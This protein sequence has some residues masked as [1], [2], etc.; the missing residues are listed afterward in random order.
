MV[1]SLV[2]SIR[3]TLSMIRFSHSVFALPFAL[4]SLFLAA[5]GWPSGR[6]LLW[7]LAAMVA[8]RS[9]AMGMNRLADRR[10][11]A[12]NPR[13]ANR[14]L[15]TGALS[16]RFVGLFTL[17][18][19]FTFVFAAWMLNDVALLLSPAVLLVLFGYSFLKRFTALA[20]FGV[21]LALGLSPLGAWIAVRGADWGDLRIPV[22]LGAGVLAWVAG[23]DVI[24]AC[25]DAEV[26]RELGLHSIPARLGVKRALQVAALLHVLCVLAF[27][28]VAPLAGLGW[29]Y[30]GAVCL[31]AVLLLAEH[32]IVSP[33]DLSRV[34]AAFFTAN[35]IVAVILGAAGIADVL[36]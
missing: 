22:A 23:F 18:C 25:Q 5:E 33:A 2:R 1:L 10:F 29:P 6:V 12:A 36:L 9:A 31:A 30:L 4:F 11:D 28:A 13:T 7:V 27:A 16:V 8:A 21:G 34:N 26:D 17:V 20:H 19:A 15:V 14:E 24:Y 35:G 32:S 3:D